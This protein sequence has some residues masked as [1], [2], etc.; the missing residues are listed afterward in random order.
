MPLNPI[1][2]PPTRV[3]RLYPLMTLALMVASSVLV[4]AWQNSS[5]SS[6]AAVRDRERQISELKADNEKLSKQTQQDEASIQSQKTQIDQLGGQLKDIQSQLDT[7]TQQLKDAG[8]QLQTQKDQLA[9]NS[10]ELQQLRD[11][12]PLFSFENKSSL[13]NIEQKEADVREVVTNAY[14]YIQRLYGKPYLLHSI[15]ITF[16]DSFTIAGASGEI[17][18]SNSSQGVS[19]DIHL[20][21]FD[22]NNPQDVET[23]SH[24]MIHGFRGLA[25][26]DTSALEEGSTVAANQV[27]DSLMAQD[28]KAP[29][30]TSYINLTPSEYQSYNNALTIYADNTKFYHDPNISQV[31]QVIGYAWYQLYLADHNFFNKFNDAYYARVQRGQTVDPAG[32]R[33]II[34]SIVSQVGGVPIAQ[35]LQNNKA[36]NPS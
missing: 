27:V 28:G 19:I 13:S 17:Q 2:R 6:D 3:S 20:K 12:P 15:T 26:I 9:S 24:E 22:K 23:M 32:V 29:H 21:D 33:D 10:T 7:T 18:I 11:R 16:V 34:A 14:D 31:Y 36:F 25:V 35:Y 1:L 4:Y 30:S 5:L 8:T